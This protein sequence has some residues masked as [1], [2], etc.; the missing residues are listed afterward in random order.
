MNANRPTLRHIADAL[1][2]S[3][4]TVSR[5]LAGKDNVNEVTRAR[6]RDEAQRIGYVPNV[7][8]RSLVLGSNNTVGLV[9]TNPSNPLYAQLISSV[10]RQAK[11][12]GYSTLLLVSEESEEGEQSAVES[13]LRAAV[14]GAIVVPVQ[15]KYRHWRRL[16]DAGVPIV[17]VNR[18]LPELD[19]DHVGVDNAL[20]AYLAT[21]H[22]IAEGAKRIWALEED[23]PITTIAARVEGFRAAMG[24]AGLPVRPSEDVIYVPTRRL[25]SFA[26]PWQS[27]EAYHVCVR[28]L[29]Q[30]GPPD[31]VVAGNDYFALGLIRALDEA[32]HP[33]PDDV[34]IVGYGD[35]P[36]SAYIKPALSSVELPGFE[37]GARAVD[38]LLNRK[39]LPDSDASTEL[40]APRLT[41][42]RSSR[43]ASR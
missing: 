11:A 28:A 26:L 43:R 25:E 21:K 16:Q 6:I 7:L 41:V 17:L 29:A 39:R 8:A 35:H 31:A 40:I 42:R 34:L 30:H 12:A 36:Y 10:E 19:T 14:D 37:I 22:V 24:E 18:N 27:E 15:T 9:I 20:G 1:G 2:V 23:L 3:V 5:A 4:N 33:V 13:L 38:M 32:G